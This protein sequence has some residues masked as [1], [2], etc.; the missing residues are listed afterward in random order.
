MVVHCKINFDPSRIINEIRVACD[1]AEQGCSIDLSQIN[2]KL[3]KLK[4]IVN[5]YANHL[6]EICVRMIDKQSPTNG[7]IFATTDWSDNYATDSEGY[8]IFQGV[9]GVCAKIGEKIVYND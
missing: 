4:C 6:G 9:R 1:K 7:I 2:E 8:P 3:K 5:I